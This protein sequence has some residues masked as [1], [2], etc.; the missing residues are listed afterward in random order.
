MKKTLLLTLAILAVGGCSSETLA[1]DVDT[2]VNSIGMKLI[3]IEP[4]SFV[5]GQAQGGDWDERPLHKVTITK[6]F[7]M[8]GT[9]V[10][11]AQYEQF[12]P[13]HNKLRG[14]LGFSNLDDEA[15]VFVSWDDAV[16]F[17]KWLSEKEGKTYRLPTEAE[18]EY[19][20]R[21]GTATAYHTGDE[22]PKEYHKNQQQT[23]DPKPV[24]L[25]VAATPPNP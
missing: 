11:N 7:F 9:E 15:V 3:R 1:K 14:K 22:F 18:W 8:S 19:A 23:W 2:F 17:C 10:A 13:D 4:G 16:N 5:M 6:S 24:S 25:K 12:D 21:A 20:C